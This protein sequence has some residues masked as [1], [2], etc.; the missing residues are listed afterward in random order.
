MNYRE[1]VQRCVACAGEENYFCTLKANC[2][3]LLVLRNSAGLSILYNKRSCLSSVQ[4]GR[5]DFWQHADSSI[6]HWSILAGSCQMI[7]F[8][9]WVMVFQETI[10]TLKSS[11][12]LRTF[13]CCSRKKLLNR[14]GVTQLAWHS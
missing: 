14:L 13:Q 8:F 7:F 11:C 1:D 3:Q 12:V 5:T 4:C 2:G 6:R 9:L 10:K